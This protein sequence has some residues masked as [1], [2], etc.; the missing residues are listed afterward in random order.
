M[1]FFSALLPMNTGHPLVI[2]MHMVLILYTMQ[3]Q[4]SFIDRDIFNLLTDFVI[5]HVPQQCFTLLFNSPSFRLAVSLSCFA[6]T[7]YCLNQNTPS[8][9]RILLPAYISNYTLQCL[10]DKLT[11]S[12]I[13]GLSYVK[14]VTLLRIRK[15]FSK[16]LPFKKPLKHHELRVNVPDVFTQLASACA[17]LLEE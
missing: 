5:S 11:C 9:E 8:F 7:S 14:S 1:L 3:S 15:G 16:T 4:V 10:I 2:M 12:H 17:T 6:Q 13:L